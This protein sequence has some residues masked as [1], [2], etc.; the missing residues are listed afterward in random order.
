ML[1][2]TLAV[3]LRL[4]SKE[5]WILVF[6]YVLPPL[7]HLEAERASGTHAFRLPSGQV[8]CRLLL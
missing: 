6:A 1:L 5:C 8:A 2:R 3:A 7:S 4:T